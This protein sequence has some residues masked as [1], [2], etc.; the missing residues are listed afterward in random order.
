[1]NLAASRLMAQRRQIGVAPTYGVAPAY[2]LL[3]FCRR[4]LHDQF[5]EKGEQLLFFL[6]S[7]PAE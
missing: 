1:M 2:D 5:V 7:Q 6:I 4:V 3:F